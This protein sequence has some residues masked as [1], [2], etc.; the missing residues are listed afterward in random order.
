MRLF[1]PTLGRSL[2]C[3][4]QNHS[5]FLDMGVSV[6][7][8]SG[9]KPVMRNRCDWSEVNYIHVHAFSPSF[10]ESLVMASEFVGLW[11]LFCWVVPSLSMWGSGKSAP[12]PRSSC[13]SL[14]SSCTLRC[15][16]P[17]TALVAAFRTLGAWEGHQTGHAAAAGCG[18]APLEGGPFLCA[19]Y[20]ALAQIPLGRMGEFSFSTK[21]KT[22]F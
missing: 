9:R 12:S 17:M 1:P 13:L 11:V 6:L 4:E 3:F 14:V 20:Q 15:H 18:Q 5:C 16:S 10:E 22:V 21:T 19:S 2:F 8:L 7:T